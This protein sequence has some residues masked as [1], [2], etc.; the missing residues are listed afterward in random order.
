[1]ALKFNFDTHQLAFYRKLNATYNGAQR[2]LLQ[3]DRTTRN[4]VLAAVAA[5]PALLLFIMKTVWR[6]YNKIQNEAGVRLVT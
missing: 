5:R 3:L 4:E 2:S 6:F 1:M